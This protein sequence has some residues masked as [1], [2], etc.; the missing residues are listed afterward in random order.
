MIKNYLKGC[1]RT[2]NIYKYPKYFCTTI[3]TDNTNK[4]EIKL[5]TIDDCVKEIEAKVK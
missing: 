4:N 5:L 2:S 3:N 1:F